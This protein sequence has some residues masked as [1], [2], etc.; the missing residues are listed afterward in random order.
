V[1]A[2]HAN[3]ERGETEPLQGEA[4]EAKALQVADPVE[5]QEVVDEDE[6]ALGLG[7]LGEASRVST[8]AVC[9]GFGGRGG[10]VCFAVSSQRLRLHPS[11]SRTRPVICFR[12]GLN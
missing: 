8:E 5:L 1:P 10:V 12:A 3:G 4:A 9:V 11:L 7:P 2:A 6:G